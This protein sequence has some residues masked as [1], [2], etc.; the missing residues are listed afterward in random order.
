[1]RV[2]DEKTLY[3]VDLSLRD[4]LTCVAA[5]ACAYSSNPP[6]GVEAGRTLVPRADLINQTLG[7]D[8]QLYD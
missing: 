7:L 4:T 8:M 5:D 3:K 2:A 1:M 6:T